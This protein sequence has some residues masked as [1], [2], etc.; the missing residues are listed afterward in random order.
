MLGT[1]KKLKIY[2]EYFLSYI[3]YRE[4]SLPRLKTRILHGRSIFISGQHIPSA[5]MTIRTRVQDVLRSVSLS[6]DSVCL[7][8]C[9]KVSEQPYGVYYK[10]LLAGVAITLKNNFNR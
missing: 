7:L 8:H 2:D 5:D 6:V 9:T 1:H 3:S 10:D 4:K